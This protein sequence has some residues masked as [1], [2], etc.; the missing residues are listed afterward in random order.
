MIRWFVATYHEAV[1]N[2]RFLEHNFYV[3]L[4][5][6]LKVFLMLRGN[7]F[8]NMIFLLI[9]LY[10][11]LL[12]QLS[13][14]LKRDIWVWVY[15][16]DLDILIIWLYCGC[17]L[18]I[19]RPWPKLAH[20]YAFFFWVVPISRIFRLI[21]SVIFVLLSSRLL[22][23]LFF[24]G[25]GSVAEPA[26]EIVAPRALL[27]LYRLLFNILWCLSSLR[28][29]S[30]LLMDARFLNLNIIEQIA[31]VVLEMPLA[32]VHRLL[33]RR[34]ELANS[35]ERL[36]FILW[37]I[38][39]FITAILPILLLEAPTF[40][41]GWEF[42]SLAGAFAHPW[43]D[44]LLSQFHLFALSI[45]FVVE[46]CLIWCSLNVAV[47]V[48]SLWIGEIGARVTLRPPLFRRV[49]AGGLLNTLVAKHATLRLS[50]AALIASRR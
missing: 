13:L 7:A 9:L 48:S 41:I 37:I 10:S 14:L 44:N 36:A 32:L 22:L 24:L 26:T 25:S 8:E 35:N 11:K 23:L 46:V 50:H 18:V 19:A 42:D 29:E 31:T 16:T 47:S 40:K 27:L 12:I 49:F 43:W 6:Y 39:F 30:L 4:V 34:I 17:L 20:I 21:I 15:I 5:F 28:L 45:I 38:I 3:T 2:L 33:R 1:L